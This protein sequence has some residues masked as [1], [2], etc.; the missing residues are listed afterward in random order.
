MIEKGRGR[1]QPGIR[2]AFDAMTGYR[3]KSTDR[4]VRY[5]GIDLDP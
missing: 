2:P 1:G 5:A 4:R 3:I